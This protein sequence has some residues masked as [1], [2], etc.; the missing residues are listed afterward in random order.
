MIINTKNIFPAL[1]VICLLVYSCTGKNQANSK[2]DHRIPVI[3]D[4]DANNELDDQHAIA[5]M[6]FSGQTFD[7]KGITVNRTYNGGTIDDQFAE[8]ER[9]VKLCN[10]VSKIRIYKGASNTYDE[11]ADHIAES[12][13]DGA[14]AVNFIIDC[15]NSTENQKLVLLPIGKLTNI[16]LALKK[17]PSIA[18][19]I[20]IV[21]LGTNY[22][23]PGEYNFINDTTALKPILESNV[24]FEIVMVRYGKSSGTDAVKAY[25]KDFQVKMPG[26]GPKISEPVTGRHGDSFNCFGDYSVN[27]FENFRGNPQT[28]PLFDMAAVAIVKNPEW[29]D[30]VIIGA[31]LYEN[32]KWIN[33][34]DNQRKIAIWENF[35]TDSIM[36]DFYYTMENYKLAE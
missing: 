10:C 26:K 24:E 33:Q 27:L 11:I 28:R 14:E 29:A 30:K 23:E 34:P 21:W 19:K 3:L 5:Y 7:V 4:T 16:S 18:S 6:L 2:Q 36:K 35:V 31:P 13:F 9:I 8:A 20:R 32:G 1:A 25:L 15:A 17:D 12:D 22:P